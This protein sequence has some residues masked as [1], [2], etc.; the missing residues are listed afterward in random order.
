ML[1]RRCCRAV[2]P[3]LATLAL[4]SCGGDD[5]SDAS[6]TTTTTAEP[7]T[8]STTLSP[9]AEVEAAYHEVEAVMTEQGLS[10][11]PEDSRLQ[12]LFLE[13]LLSEIQENL[14]QAALSNQVYEP[15]EESSY[16]IRSTTLGPDG[17]TATLVVCS[18]SADRLVD[19]DTGDVLAQGVAT[20]KSEASFRW[21]DGRWMLED[22]TVTDSWDGARS[23]DG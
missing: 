16:E 4:A 9:E 18:V 6:E 10:P 5:S 15:G 17:Q 8:T 22:L 13:P 23:C 2:A 14:R 21:V 11:D 7:A 12:D 20:L 3:V 1:T 19:Y